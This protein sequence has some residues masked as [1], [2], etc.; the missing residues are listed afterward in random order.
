MVHKIGARSEKKIE[1]ILLEDF[2]KVSGKNG[3]L[4]RVAKA[5]LA[6]PDGSVREVVFPVVDEETLSK[7]VKEAKSTG[8]AYQEQVQ[9]KMRSSYVSYYRPVISAVLG[10]LEFRSNNA[11]HRP[12]IRAL[13]LLKA[14]AGST[15]RFY[16]DDDDVPVEGVVPAGWHELVFNADGKGTGRNG[17]VRIDRVVYELCVLGA[18]RDGLRSKEVWVVGADRYRNPD[19]DLPADFDER[20]ARY[21]EALGQPMEAD[22]FVKGLQWDMNKALGML[23]ENVPYN[24]YLR[25]RER[26]KARISLS[27]LP[28]QPEPPNL[29]DLG[30]EIAGRWPM[31]S[32]L[33]ILKEADLRL[34]LTDHFTTVAS[35]QILN[36]NTLRKRLLLCLYGLGTNTGLKRISAGDPESGYQDLRYVRR[37]F[38][39][40]EQLRAAIARVVDGIFVARSTEIWGEATTA[41][42]SD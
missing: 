28:A 30:I 41:C 12:V 36:L 35:R 16:E 42:A 6:D 24:P 1:K 38:V 2:K 9:L 32:L 37:R 4:F 20:R 29:D 7:V 8:A 26:G 10:S 40:K 27:P 15:K 14:Y 21:Y 31:T 5:A 13:G 18:L 11:A 23:D 39:H 22:R 19:E 33:D 17:S 34:G 25:L 3:L